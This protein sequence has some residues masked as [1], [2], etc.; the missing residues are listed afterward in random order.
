MSIVAI[1]PGISTGVAIRTSEDQYL[2]LVVIEPYKLWN[3]LEVHKPSSLCFENF[4]SSGLISKDGQATIRLCGAIEAVCYL[5]HIKCVIQMPM[6]RKPFIPI[7]R[8]MLRQRFKKAPISHEVDALSHLLLY[9]HRVSNGTLD[10][11][12]SQRRSTYAR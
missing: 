9:E 7:A 1:D 2:T 5:K 4:A 12:N 3:I 8:E 6:E 10:Q 11:I